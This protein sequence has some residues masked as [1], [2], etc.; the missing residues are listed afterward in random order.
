MVDYTKLEDV[1][2][3]LAESQDADSDNRGKVR[4]VVHFLHKPDGQW[5]PNIVNNMAGRPRYTFDMCNPIVD[6]IASEMEQSDFDIRIRPAGGDA[7]KDLAATYDGIIRNIENISGAVDIFNAAGRSMIEAGYDGWRVVQD[8]ASDGSF[9]Q[10][11][12]IK[13]IANFVDRVWFDPSS[14]LQDRSDS[15]YCFVLQVLSKNEYDERWPE[16]SGRSVSDGNSYNVYQNKAEQITVGEFLYRKDVSVELVQMSNGAVYEV[17][18]KFNSIADE[19]AAEGITE[20]RRRK[21]TK[22][23]VYSRLFDG[24]DWL[25]KEQETVFSY[26]PVIPTYGNFKI[27]ENKLIYRGAVEKWMD[28]QRVYNYAKSRQIEEGALAPRAKYWGTPAQ[29]Q[30]HES[31]LQTMNTNA[32]PIQTYNHVDGVPPPFWTGGAQVN[33]GLQTTADDAARSVTV[34]SGMYSANMAD[35]PG[36]QSGVAIEKLQNKGDA[37]TIKYFKS[38]EIAIRHTAKYWSMLSPKFMTLSVRFAYWE[39]MGRLRW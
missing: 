18:D 34:S 23:V 21:K 14:E 10:D 33:P 30:G 15:R 2:R 22:H 38:Q 7:T 9:E 39:K 8:W 3:L 1:K 5:E 19:L 29:F 16:G 24:D 27:S 12:I 17:D 28:G 13:P 25:T 37:G 20:E 11:L 4:E 36:L 31:T 32:H 26:I 35:N 6:Q